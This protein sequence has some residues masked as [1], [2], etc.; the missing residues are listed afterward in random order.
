VLVAIAI[1]VLVGAK[2]AYADP[3]PRERG[4]VFI[5]LSGTVLNT[6]DG[7]NST[8][9]GSAYLEYGLSDRLTIGVSANHTQI[10]YSHV[11]GFARWA[12]S[13]PE[14]SLKLA[15]NVGLGQSRQDADWGPMVRLGF[16]VGRS[17]SLWTPGWW[18]VRAAVEEHAVFQNPIY[19]LD[20]TVGWNITPRIKA[21]VDLENSS[22]SGTASSRTARASLAWETAPGAFLV[23]GF[24]VKDVDTTFLGMRLGWWLSF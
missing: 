18:S 2:A 10:D 14:R 20:A 17:M 19:K 6:P 5:A 13:A 11:F 1:V 15:A 7:L 12:V 3:W 22:R 4:Q 23:G 21:F 9:E 16:S 24:E 8:V